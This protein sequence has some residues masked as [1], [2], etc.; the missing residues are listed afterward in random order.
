MGLSGRNIS[1]D[2]ENQQVE[3]A[4]SKKLGNNTRHNYV[5]QLRIIPNTGIETEN[6]QL[7]KVIRNGLQKKVSANIPLVSEG[8]CGKHTVCMRKRETVLKTKGQLKTGQVLDK[9]CY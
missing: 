4:K 1:S 8:R 2:E 5:L 9:T 3:H 6:K 7:Y